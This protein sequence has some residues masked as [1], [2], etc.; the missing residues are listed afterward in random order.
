MRGDN[1][2]DS[3]GAEDAGMDPSCGTCVG[4]IVLATDGLVETKKMIP[5]PRTNK[6]AYFQIRF[7][8]LGREYRVHR[9]SLST[10]HSLDM[11]LRLLSLMVSG[12]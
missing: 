7:V 6:P 11:E 10:D 4:R 3:D 9:I 5:K 1:C 8:A 12:G 2:D